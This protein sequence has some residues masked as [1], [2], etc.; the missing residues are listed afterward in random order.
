MDYEVENDESLQWIDIPHEQ[1]ER[2]TLLR[3]IEE[4]VTRDG[5]NW[6]E[7]S[8]T[9]DVKVTQVMVQLKQRKIKVVFDLQTQTANLVVCC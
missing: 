3:M 9:L 4:F 8:G 1:L 7:D 5:S 2:D 6:E